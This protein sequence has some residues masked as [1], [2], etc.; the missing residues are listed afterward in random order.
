MIGK[1][2]EK[3]SLTE[4]T[5]IKALNSTQFSCPIFTLEIPDSGKLFDVV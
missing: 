3:K 4:G 2:Q 1:K 5:G